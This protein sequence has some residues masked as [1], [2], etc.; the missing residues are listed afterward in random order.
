M[1]NM[2]NTDLLKNAKCPGLVEEKKNRKLKRQR[3]NLTY[4]KLKINVFRIILQFCMIVLL[5]IRQALKAQVTSKPVRMKS[6]VC[7]LKLYKNI[8]ERITNL[9]LQNI[10]VEE[11]KSLKRFKPSK[12]DGETRLT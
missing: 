12:Y 11:D 6:Y 3:V 7:T 8:L 10:V 2:A 4:S 5:S 9:E 1:A